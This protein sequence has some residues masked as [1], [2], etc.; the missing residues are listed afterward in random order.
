MVGRDGGRTIRGVGMGGCRVG[1]G[2]EPRL[3]VC[4]SIDG[5]AHVPL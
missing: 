2:E 4:P 3:L 5:G 1:A